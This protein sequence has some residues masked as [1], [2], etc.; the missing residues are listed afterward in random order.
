MTCIQ[1]RNSAQCQGQ[2]H[3]SL[4]FD[5]TGNSQD[6]IDPEL[7][8]IT[9]R[10]AN[11]HSNVARL[12][13]AAFDDSQ[14]GVSRH[15]FFSHYIPG[16]GTPF[17]KIGDSGN[18][19]STKLSLGNGYMGADRINWGIVQVL[20][21]VHA[22]LTGTML[23]EGEHAQTIVNHA[24]QRLGSLGFETPYRNMVLRAWTEKLE[25][26]IKSHQRKVTQINLAVFG[27]SR[28]AAIARAFANWLFALLQPHDGGYTLAGVPVRLYFMGLFDTVASVGVPDIVPGFDGHM[29][30]ADGN[31]GI[32]PAVEQCVHFIALHEQRASFPLEMAPQIKHVAYP[33]MHSDVGGGYQP[34]EQGKAMPGWGHSPQLSQVP[35]IDMHYEAIKAGVPLRSS[36]E[37][38]QRSD[39]ATDFDCPPALATAV[40]DFYRTCGISS[41]TSGETAV[42]AVL[43][44][45]TLQYL[46]WRRGLLQAGQQLATRRFYK[47]A[48]LAKD[49]KDLAEGVQD[50]ADHERALRLRLSTNHERQADWGL[51]LNPAGTLASRVFLDDFS[52]PV[53]HVT[54]HL[55]AAL[56]QQADPPPAVRRLMDDYI[57][58]SRCAFQVAGAM[59]PRRLTDGYFRFR[60]VFHR[61]T[62]LL[63]RATQSATQTIKKVNDLAQ[64][65]ARR[66]AK[67]NARSQDNLQLIQDASPALNKELLHRASDHAFGDDPFFSH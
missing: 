48:A 4:F 20:N 8:G 15:G 62:G 59:E 14:N 51:R 46:K 1:D 5:G 56:D 43:Q 47:E 66:V 52:Q 9:Q 2:V 33:G 27:F 6:W 29:D 35:L 57:H 65:A 22:Y 60:T 44:A 26:V 12:Y 10:I 34:G 45:H 30:W 54:R 41:T 17:D 39:L 23:L 58:D 40:N 11:K 25:A 36:E 7:G 31:M 67:A 18:W 28:G 38:K 24:S 53:K 13:N 42:Q 32:S 63:D 37:I 49:Q 64:A 21:S 61:P 55:L 3:V 19:I 16:I 50:F